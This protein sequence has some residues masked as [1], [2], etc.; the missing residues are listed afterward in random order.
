MGFACRAANKYATA[1]GNQTVAGGT[2]TLTAGTGTV[3]AAANSVAFGKYNTQ[4]I[5]ML[6][7]IGQGTSGSARVDV[8]SIDLSGNTIIAGNA[9][10]GG[11]LTVTGELIVPSTAGTSVNSMW[12]V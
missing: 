12:I 3:A 2:G 8:F 11:N 5:N 10:V 7:Q 1:L 6:F 4:N 9:T